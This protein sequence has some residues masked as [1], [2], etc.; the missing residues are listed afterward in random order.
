V[1]GEFGDGQFYLSHIGGC[2]LSHGDRVSQSGYL[3]SPWRPRVNHIGSAG[4]LAK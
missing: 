1:S 3:V 2:T 4:V